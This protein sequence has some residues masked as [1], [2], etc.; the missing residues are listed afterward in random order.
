MY[1]ADYKEH[2]NAIINPALLWEYDLNNF[3][4]KAMRNVVVQRVIER[5]WPNDWWAV[6]NLYGENGMREIIRDLPYLNDK[7]MYFVSYIFQIPLNEMAC[8]ERKQ[9]RPTHWNS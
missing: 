8:F 1:F 3:D 4:Y 7:D 9:L 5:G 2:K 6:L